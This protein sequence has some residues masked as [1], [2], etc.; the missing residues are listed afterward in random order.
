MGADAS[1]LKPVI[2]SGIFANK[3]RSLWDFVR[4]PQ[5]EMTATSAVQYDWQAAILG[6]ELCGNPT[7]AHE[8]QQ[9]LSGLLA[10]EPAA[11]SLV[12]LLLVFRAARAEK[13]PMLVRD[14]GEAYYRWQPRNTNRPS[15]LENVPRSVAVPGM[16]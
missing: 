12:G 8:R 4:P 16:P 13:M 9:L 10:G 3:I 5:P 2:N 6:P 1:L 14:L 11:T 15:E 7:I